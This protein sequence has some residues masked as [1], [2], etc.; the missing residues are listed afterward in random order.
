MH[1]RVML[2]SKTESRGLADSISESPELKRSNR[3]KTR[4][5]DSCSIASSHVHERPIEISTCQV[6]RG[7]SEHR[8]LFD[9]RL[10]PAEHATPKG[11]RMNGADYGAGGTTPPAP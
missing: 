6:F 2:R 7:A 9:A 5:T 1:P 3:L 4:K 8:S 10:R 11:C